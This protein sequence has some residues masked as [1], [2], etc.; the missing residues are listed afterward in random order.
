M[1]II[2]SILSEWYQYI[3]HNV[4]WNA[5]EFKTELV[6]IRIL[7]WT[8]SVLNSTSSDWNP[9]RILISTSACSVD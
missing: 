7:I 1:T 9:Y 6:Q 4:D 2:E 8:G 5:V 3:C